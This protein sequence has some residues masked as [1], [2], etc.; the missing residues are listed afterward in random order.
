MKGNGRVSCAS[1][2]LLTMTVS[3]VSLFVRHRYPLPIC[4][5][6]V[7][8]LDDKDIFDKFLPPVSTTGGVGG[9]KL[10]DLS[11]SPQSAVSISRLVSF[12]L[13]VF[14]MVASAAPRRES[15]AVPR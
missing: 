12:Q 7:C 14:A 11:L 13:A 2:D 8:G 9:R 3:Q 1:M 10:R 4:E 5:N 15:K 6:Q